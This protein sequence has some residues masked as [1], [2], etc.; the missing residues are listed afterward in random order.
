M[1][2]VIWGTVRR[3]NV[4]SGELSVRETVLWGTVRRRNL[5]GEL[6]IWEMPVKEKS[7]REMSIGELLGYLKL[8]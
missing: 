1:K 5:V 8:I 3:E 2:Y 6:P 7:V 4:C